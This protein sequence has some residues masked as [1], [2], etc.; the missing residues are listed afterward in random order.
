MATSRPGSGSAT[1]EFRQVELPAISLTGPGAGTPAPRAQARLSAA[2][3][4]T[5]T[6]RAS[7]NPRTRAG[8]RSPATVQDGRGTGSR[9]GARA[10]HARGAG[11]QSRGGDSVTGSPV[12][13]SPAYS[14]GWRNRRAAPKVAG[15]CARIQPILAAV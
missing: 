14:D 9:A 10:G 3:A 1:T 15:S 11:A 2:P 12:R 7:P 4:I 6:G 8:R 5:G 13:A